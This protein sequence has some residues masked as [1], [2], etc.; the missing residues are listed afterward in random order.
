MYLCHVCISQ[1]TLYNVHDMYMY[2][3]VIIYVHVD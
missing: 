2:V 3:H 1:D